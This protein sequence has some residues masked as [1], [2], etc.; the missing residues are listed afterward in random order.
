MIIKIDL[1]NKIIIINGAISL[2]E[3]LD[4]VSED[5]FKDEEEWTIVP[6]MFFAFTN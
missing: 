1:Q 6:E 2:T 4:T 3:F 5:L